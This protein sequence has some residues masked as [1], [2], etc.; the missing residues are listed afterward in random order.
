MKKAD[1]K[2]LIYDNSTGGEF[3]GHTFIIVDT[4]EFIEKIE[5]LSK[6]RFDDTITWLFGD[7]SEWGFSDEYTVCSECG[8]NVIR[9]SPDSYSWTPDFYEDLDNGI[10][11]CK[12]CS[13]SFADDRIESTQ[14]AIRLG[15]QPHSLEF[16]F[17]LD[18]TWV[19][20]PHPYDRGSYT[21]QWENG[22]F[23]GMNCD[24]LRQG[25]IVH[26]YKQNGQRM[27]DVVFRVYPS[28]FYVEWDTYI[29]VNPELEGQIII[30]D[31]FLAHLSSEFQSKAN[32][33]Y[34]IATLMKNALQEAGSNFRKIGFDPNT[35]EIQNKNYDTLDDYLASK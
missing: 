27:F 1:I 9:T 10:L 25:K 35:G 18:D 26:A 17:D 23:E 3:D 33:P 15:K 30:T 24:P 4:W 16:M 29:R 20:I 31:D 5:K 32:F 7:G 22:M 2:Q 12:D 21:S 19:R 34:D 6:R 8:I 11:A 13:S 14:E 28:Q